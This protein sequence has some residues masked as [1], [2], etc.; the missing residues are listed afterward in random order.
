VIYI[1]GLVFDD[2]LVEEEYA[3]AAFSETVI[4][5]PLLWLLTLFQMV[6]KVKHQPPLNL[7]QT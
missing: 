5:T 7:K 3:L 1:K 4:N 2:K 6:Q